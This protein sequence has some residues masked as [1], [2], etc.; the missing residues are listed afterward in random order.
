MKK[1]LKPIGLLLAVAVLMHWLWPDQQRWAWI[2]LAAV[3]GLG[4][5]RMCWYLGVTIWLPSREDRAAWSAERRQ[6]RR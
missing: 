6:R 5:L 3:I 4:V 2:A 1:W